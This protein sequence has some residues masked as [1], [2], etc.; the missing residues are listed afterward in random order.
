MAWGSISFE[1]QFVRHSNTCAALTRVHTQGEI[2]YECEI[3]EGVTTPR[4]RAVCQ[5]VHLMRLQGTC[6]L[7]V[8]TCTRAHA[9]TRH[10]SRITP[11]CLHVTMEAL[12]CT[13][14]ARRTLAAG[15]K[16]VTLASQRCTRAGTRHRTHNR[17]S[18]E[19]R[20]GAKKRHTKPCLP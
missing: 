3:Q 10:Y 9:H 8:C 20:N 2:Q 18:Q 15:R 6:S 11:G 17:L 5:R 12:L 16:T 14:F 7:I 1:W 13:G 19:G 4:V